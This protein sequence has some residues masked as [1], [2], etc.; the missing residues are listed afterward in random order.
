[1]TATVVLP[2]VLAERAGGV[3]R[4]EVTEG[5]LG[6]VISEIGKQHAA[7]AE[8][9]VG[10]DGLSRF[11]NVYINDRNARSTGGL[12]S[13]VSESDEIVVVPAVAGG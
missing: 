7:L 12:L 3:Q 6:E 8:L 11:V 13:P 9:F 4:L 2:A 1:M 5:T 10:R